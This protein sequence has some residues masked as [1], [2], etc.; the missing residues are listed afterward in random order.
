MTD[1]VESHSERQNVPLFVDMDGTLLRTDVAQELL[2]RAF[3]S[4]VAIAAVLSGVLKSGVAGVKRALADHVEFRADLLPYDPAVLA[5]VKAA[6]RAGRRVIL[7]T[8]A[9]R[10]VAQEVADFTGLF[11]DIIASEPGHNMKGA[12]K[13]AAIRAIAGQGGFEYLGDSA[14][15]LPIWR[16]AAWRGFARVPAKARALATGEAVTLVPADD[17]APKAAL[18]RAMRPQQWA[19][20][21]LLFLPLLFAHLYNDPASLLRA[22]LGFAAFSLCASAVYLIND[23]LDIDADRAHPT[24]CKRPFAAGALRPTTGVAAA[25]GLLLAGVSIGFALVSVAFGM[26]LLL[27]VALTKAYSFWLKAYS[28]IDVVVLSVLYTIRIVAGAAAILV[29]PSPWIL[30]FSLFFFLSLAY[31]KRYIE[32]ARDTSSGRLPAR[33][34]YAGDLHVVQTFGIANAALSLLTMAEYISSNAVQEQYQAPGLLWLVLPVMM[35]WTYRAWMWANRDQIGDD[36]VAF[37]LKDRISRVS[38]LIVLAVVLSAR[39]I[40]LDW[41]LP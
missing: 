40:N 35:F 25:L 15:D 29:V 39:Y 31:M 16:D 33:N 6:R 27:Y 22:A 34:Y 18:W 9:D 5:Y 2:V 13:L 3:K 4:P 20:N 38:G 1:I 21:L 37:A 36:P 30:T 26:V 14:A 11:D 32:L 7:A 17:K 24:K 8:A 28:T 12:A 23:M 10:K 41:M 19:K